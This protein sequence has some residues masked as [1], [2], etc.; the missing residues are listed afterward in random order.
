MLGWI[1]WI[2]DDPAAHPGSG[3]RLPSVD[4]VVIVHLVATWFM[5]G[6]IWTI[7]VVHYPL[8]AEVGAD[9]YVAYQ[10]GH[11]ERIGPLLALPWLIEGVCT[12]AL[13]L[14]ADRRIRRLAVVGAAAMGGVLLISGL[15]S[16]PAH[17]ELAD[18]FDAA[19]HDRL[20]TINL[21]RTMLW[22][23]RGVVAVAMLVEVRRRWGQRRSVA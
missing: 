17:G 5:V 21:V 6:L 13:L 3:R 7:Q 16:A 23:L 19:V 4:S 9:A 10:R 11:I 22:T 14:V 12:A 20:M 8:F 15:W 18:G 2:G 1:G